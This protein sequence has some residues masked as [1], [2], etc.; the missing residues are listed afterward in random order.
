MVQ[1]SFF[2]AVTTRW[3]SVPIA[4]K[5]HGTRKIVSLKNG[6]GYTIDQNLNMTGEILKQRKH[7][8]SVKNIRRHKARKNTRRN[9][10][11]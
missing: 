10:R 5:K 3:S 7:K 6:K 1:K 2:Q 4:G 9:R 8:M 11:H